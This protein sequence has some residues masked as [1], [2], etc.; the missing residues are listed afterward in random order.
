M[1]QIHITPREQDVL[2]QLV[3]GRPN[4]LIAR[5]LGISP[6]TVRDHITCMLRKAG[7]NSRLELSMLAMR[8]DLFL[9]PPINDGMVC[10]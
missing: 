8:N 2:H 7:V 6:Y 5:E 9:P 4:K 10:Q 1:P 3:R